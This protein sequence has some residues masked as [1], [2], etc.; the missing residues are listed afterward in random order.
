MLGQLGRAVWPVLPAVELVLDVRAVDGEDRSAGIAL[1]EL[2]AYATV[3][4]VVTAL[5][6]RAL[7]REALG[8]LRRVAPDK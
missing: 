2:A 1:G 6:E 7:L 4:V 3:V 8:Y 5:A